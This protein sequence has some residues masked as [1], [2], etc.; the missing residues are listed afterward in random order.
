MGSLIF[1]V[2]SAM[3]RNRLELLQVI[4][5]A[6][7]V[8]PR[9]LEGGLQGFSLDGVGCVVSGVSVDGEVACMQYF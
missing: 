2:Q 1:S 4:L 8:Q 6:L 7:L 3:Q 9:G 5:V